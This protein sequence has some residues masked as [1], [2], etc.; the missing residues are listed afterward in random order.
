MSQQTLWRA[1][2]V[3]GDEFYTLAADVADMIAAVEDA[4]PDYR[5]TIRTREATP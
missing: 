2:R 4:A 1:R 3:P 5:A